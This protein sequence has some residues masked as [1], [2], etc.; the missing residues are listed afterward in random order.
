MLLFLNE[1]VDSL[2]LFL[3]SILLDFR[4]ESQTD[5]CEAQDRHGE[6]GLR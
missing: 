5:E 1:Y 2:F 6:R 3:Q 4:R